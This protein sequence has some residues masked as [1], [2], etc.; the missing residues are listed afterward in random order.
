M[1][2]VCIATYNGGKFVKE[3]IESILP[4]LHRDDEIIVS[5]D[6]STD[7]TINII[8]SVGDERIRIV[9]NENERGY[10]SNFEN[11]LNNSI[12]DYI[13]LCDQDDV[14]KQNKVEYCMKQLLFYDFIVSDA[15]I[16]N[17]NGDVIGSSFY[18][19]RKV[20]HSLIGNIIK[21]GYLGCC[22]AFRR[23]I[24]NKALPFPSNHKFCTHDNWLFIVAHTYYKIYISNEKLILYRRYL[25]N[26]STGGFCNNTSVA[27]KISYRLYIVLNILLISFRNQNQ[28]KCKKKH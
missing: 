23:R 10:T 25:G 4:Q 27:F 19:K 15:D 20:Y 3:Q 8:K 2:S 24:L 12:G 9:K 16:I 18:E 13:F 22:M 5:D 21:F 17:E 28:I 14:W 11:A 7:D 26:T 6:N 1:I